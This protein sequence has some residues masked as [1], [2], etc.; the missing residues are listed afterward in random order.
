MALLG[1]AILEFAGALAVQVRRP[2]FGI[3]LMPRPAR[4]VSRV[5]GPSAG[6]CVRGAALVSLVTSRRW[7]FTRRI[8]P[9]ILAIVALVVAWY[10]VGELRHCRVETLLF[11]QPTV[12]LG[13][14]FLRETSVSSLNHSSEPLVTGPF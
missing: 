14:Q 5:A 8:A 11:R 1:S 3:L 9:R 7:R 4:W 13:A 12:A 6:A 10:H 2:R